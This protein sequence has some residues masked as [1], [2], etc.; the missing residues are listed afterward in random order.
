MV[1]HVYVCAFARLFAR[2]FTMFHEWIVM[3]HWEFLIAIWMQE[4]FLEAWG[5]ASG[6]I[7]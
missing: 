4:N 5:A 2:L 3:I 7:S 6:T 1:P